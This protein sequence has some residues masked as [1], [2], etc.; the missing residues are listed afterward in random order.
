MTAM[1]VFEAFFLNLLVLGLALL[2]DQI[3]G[4]PPEKIHPTVWMGRVV[5]YLKP[6]FR[7]RTPR[8]TRM[9]GC[10]LW[11]VCVTGFAVATIAIVALAEKYLGA[12]GYVLASTIILKTSFALKSWDSHMLPVAEAL[13]SNNIQEARRLC[14]KTVRR[15]LSNANEQHVISASIETIAEGVIDGYTSPIFYFAVFA[16]PGAVVYRMI[17]TLDSMVGYKDQEHMDL[18]WF[19][20]KM[21]TAANYVPARIT[22]FVMLLASALAGEN[23]R[24]AKN[25]LSRYRNTPE[26][27]N[28]GWPMSA[29]AGALGVKL[30][31]TGQYTIGETYETLKTHHVY[32]ALR[33]MKTTC[34]VFTLLVA[35]PL[36]YYGTQLIQKLVVRI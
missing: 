1:T 18:G 24:R 34:A 7:S 32:R 27:L 3:S 5:S 28:A 31:K 29:M 17:N 12:A 22:A 35:V 15:D 9:G 4:E 21:D 23:W 16:A 8:K 36:D 26:S 30:E 10:V 6:K 13:E 20:A 19:S 14:Q 2:L 25:I 33:I 11:F